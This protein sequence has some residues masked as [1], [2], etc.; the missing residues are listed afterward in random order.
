MWLSVSSMQYVDGRQC[1]LAAPIFVAA[2]CSLPVP[3]LAGGSLAFMLLSMP[4][5]VDDSDMTTNSS[6]RWPPRH[7]HHLLAAG[8]GTYRAAHLPPS[9]VTQ[10]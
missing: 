4:H 2:A 7:G 3:H 8:D 6:W 5:L 10:L 1:H 9:H